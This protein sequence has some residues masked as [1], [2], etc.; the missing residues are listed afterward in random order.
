VSRAISQRLRRLAAIWLLLGA[1]SE[2]VAQRPPTSQRMVLLKRAG[3]VAAQFYAYLRG[4]TAR[5]ILRKHG[6]TVPE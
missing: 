5:T 3:P 1:P 6:F 4:E 2:L